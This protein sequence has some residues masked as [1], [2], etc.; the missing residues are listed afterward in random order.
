MFSTF[1]YNGKGPVVTAMSFMQFIILLCSD[2]FLKSAILLGARN[3]RA[4]VLNLF[5]LMDPKIHILPL[6]T[7]R[8]FQWTPKYFKL[9]LQIVSYFTFVPFIRPLRPNV[10]DV[11][12]NKLCE[13][14]YQIFHC[15]HH[16]LHR[17]NRPT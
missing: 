13:G 4:V 11:Y 16:T 6:W 12:H 3:P 1:S 2:I 8:K 15:F 5:F 10:L 9:S 17:L 14:V 7:K